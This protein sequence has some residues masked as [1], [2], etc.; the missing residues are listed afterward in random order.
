MSP[1]QAC[2]VETDESAPDNE[3]HIPEETITLLYKL[4]PDACPKSYGFNTARLAGIPKEITIRGHRI[5]KS[6]EEETA[7]LAAFRDLLIKETSAQAVRELL[8]NLPI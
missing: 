2:M 8:A 4:V 5:S 6:L 1:P 3:D 7:R